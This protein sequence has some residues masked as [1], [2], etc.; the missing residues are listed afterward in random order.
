[1][2]VNKYTIMYENPGRNL[3]L[4]R[5]TAHNY[6]VHFSCPQD[7]RDAMCQIFNADNLPEEHVWLIATDTRNKCRGIM[8]I[9][10]GSC[11]ASMFPVREILRD[12]LMMDGI[13]FFIV[14]NHPSG[15]VSPS[16]EDKTATEKLR[17]AAKLMDLNLNDHIIIGTEGTYYSFHEN[18]WR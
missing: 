7:V 9:S 8:E 17:S 1:M 11:N 6:D 3:A 14:H 16:R 18:E 10:K 5:E 4:V 12:V 15:E 13:S 2:R